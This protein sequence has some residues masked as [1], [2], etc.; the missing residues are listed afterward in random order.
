MRKKI[1]SILCLTFLLAPL[2]LQTGVVAASSDD[3]SM[4]RGDLSHTGYLVYST[5]NFKQLTVEIGYW[6]PSGF[7]CGSC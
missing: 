2:F 5:G 7:F 3:W 1:F 6:N 4:F